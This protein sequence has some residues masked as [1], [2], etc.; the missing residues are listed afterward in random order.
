MK[1]GVGEYFKVLFDGNPA[2]IG[3]ELPPDGFYYLG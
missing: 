3:G 1:N 2:S